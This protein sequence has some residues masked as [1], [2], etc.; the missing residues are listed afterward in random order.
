MQVRHCIA[1]TVQWAVAAVAYT[2]NT[3]AG[4]IGV[5]VLQFEI[6]ASHALG[7]FVVT[8]YTYLYLYFDLLNKRTV[9]LFI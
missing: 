6:W 3:P 2:Q 9:R 1:A 7:I 4:S 5:Y 8:L